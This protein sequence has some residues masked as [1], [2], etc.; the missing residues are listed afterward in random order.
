ML[1]DDKKSDDDDDYDEE[2]AS[3]KDDDIEVPVLASL[4]NLNTNQIKLT[5]SQYH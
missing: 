1:Q 4:I 2:Q 3:K 5:C